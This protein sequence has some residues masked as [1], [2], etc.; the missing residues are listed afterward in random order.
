MM[1]LKG[2]THD[3]ISL[4]K[5]C[6]DIPAMTTCFYCGCNSIGLKGF[7]NYCRKHYC[8]VKGIKVSETLKPR[9]LSK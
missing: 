4:M 7:D 3:G 9:H 1:V 6:S 8:E 5:G 2:Y